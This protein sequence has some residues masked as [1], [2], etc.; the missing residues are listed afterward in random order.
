MADNGPGIPPEEYSKIFE[1]FYQIEEHFTGQVKGAGIG[2]AIV[3]KI[4][5][6]HD[7][8]VWVESSIGEGSRFIMS[9][10]KARL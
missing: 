5:E 9:L 1:K 3:K 6:A 7:G 2:L 10:P 8:V 4:I